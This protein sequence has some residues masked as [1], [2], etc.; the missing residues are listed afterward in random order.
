MIRH[1][2]LT[3]PVWVPSARMA[4]KWVTL[5][6]AVKVIFVIVRREQC[7]GTQIAKEVEQHLDFSAFKVIFG[8]MRREKCIGT[9]ILN[10]NGV[11]SGPIPLSRS[12]SFSCAENSASE[13]R[14]SKEMEQLLVLFRSQGQFLS[15]P[16]RTMH[17]YTNSKEVE[18][19]LVLFRSQGHIRSCES[20]IVHRNTNSRRKC[21]SIWSYSAVKVIFFLIPRGQCTE[22][23]SKE[24]E[25]HLVLFRSQGHICS[26]ESRTVHRN[27][28]SQRKCSSFW[29]YSAVKVIFFLV[30]RGQCT[31]TQIPK[32]WSS[33][34]SNF[35]LKV[36]FVLV[37]REQCIGAQILKG[38]AVASGPSP[39]S[40]S[41]SFSYVED[42]T[43][44]QIPKEVE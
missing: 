17:R 29:S 35:A 14:F 4:R 25:Q 2:F 16:A 15:H 28:N 7:I 33:I 32:K 42:C 40:R 41:Y 43:E 34:W 24:V 27:T 23:N 10:G 9:R 31:G 26:R 21:S 39:L 38:N 19:H 20:R 18:Q 13:H 44:T 36:I 22:T 30:R 5:P 1:V 8:L 6:V 11:A 37:S 3:L 12:Y